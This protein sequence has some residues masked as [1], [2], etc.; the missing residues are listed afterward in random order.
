IRRLGELNVLV[1][2]DLYAVAPRI[3]K[4][5]KRSGEGLD[6]RV[7]QC[8]A[9]GLLVIDHKSKVTSI[10][11]RLCTALLECK[12]LVTQIDERHGIAFASTFEIEQ[13]GIESRSRFDVAAFESDMIEPDDARFFCFRHGALH[14][15]LGSIPSR[16]AV[17]RP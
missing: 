4:V 5:E 15:E 10:V 7:T 13:A 16:A 6:A 11:D 12:E 17:T 9:S 1:S 3:E 8:L 2:D 14:S